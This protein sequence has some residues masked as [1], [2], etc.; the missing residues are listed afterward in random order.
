MYH[1]FNCQGGQLGV[2]TLP[3]RKTPPIQAERVES[4]GLLRGNT[5][6]KQRMKLV[7]VLA[8]GGVNDNSLIATIAMD[9][10]HAE[11][12]PLQPSSGLTGAQI[13]V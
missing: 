1:R 5:A 8:R 4:A 2:G 9:L 6:R 10:F 13:H 7:A 3:D 11:A 12:M